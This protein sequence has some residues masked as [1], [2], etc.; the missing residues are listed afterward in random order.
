MLPWTISVTLF[1][2]S[3]GFEEVELECIV[4]ETRYH[5]DVC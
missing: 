4:W 5:V 3:L 2:N 1:S